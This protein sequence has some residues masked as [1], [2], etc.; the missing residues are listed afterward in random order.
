MNLGFKDAQCLLDV[1]AEKAL[2][3]EGMKQ[4][5]Q[6]RYPDNLL[7]QTGMDVFYKGFS[8]QLPPLQ[9]ARNALLKL[10]EHSGPIKQQV[11]KYALGL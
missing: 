7:M 4:Y 11:L 5:Q 3:P 1:T 2:T 6:R 10:A 8:N 9:F